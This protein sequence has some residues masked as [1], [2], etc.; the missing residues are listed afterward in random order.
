VQ[1]ERST[2]ERIAG[3]D[4]EAPPRVDHH[5]REGPDERIEDAIADGEVGGEQQRGRISRRRVE[6]GAAGDVGGPV[7]TAHQ[8]EHDAGRRI[9]RERRL[10]G[11]AAGRGCDADAR[12]TFGGARGATASEVEEERVEVAA[13]ERFAAPL[14]ERGEAVHDGRGPSGRGPRPE[15]RRGLTAPP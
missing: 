12:E 13:G 1:K 11:R 2:T 5:R 6:N 3:E 9:G 10:A 7:E 14:Q 4:G 15:G 8:A